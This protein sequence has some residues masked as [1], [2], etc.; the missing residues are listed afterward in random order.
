[1][2]DGEWITFDEPI[3]THGRA[4]VLASLSHLSTEG[5]IDLDEQRA[6]LGLA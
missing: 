5:L 1:V 3:G 2:P 6:R 4:A